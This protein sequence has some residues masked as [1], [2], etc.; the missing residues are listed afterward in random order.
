MST[1]QKKFGN[2]KIR[3]WLRYA[4]RWEGFYEFRFSIPTFAMHLYV[5]ISPKWLAR[6]WWNVHTSNKKPHRFQIWCQNRSLRPQLRQPSMVSLDHDQERI[7][8]HAAC[9]I[10]VTWSYRKRWHVG[11][12]CDCSIF[13]TTGVNL[14]VPPCVQQASTREYAFLRCDLI[15]STAQ[16]DISLF[17]CKGPECGRF[18]WRKWQKYCKIMIRKHGWLLKE[19]LVATNKYKPPDKSALGLP[20]INE[21]DEN[22][23][24]ESHAL[25]FPSIS[26]RHLCEIRYLFCMQWSANCKDVDTYIKVNR[27][28]NKTLVWSQPTNLHYYTYLKEILDSIIIRLPPSDVAW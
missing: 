4:M 19:T 23:T 20:A 10:N 27:I 22:T 5:V 1:L 12:R 13:K 15:L 17:K 11:W 6:I 16:T 28:K 25:L 7:Q 26:A 2:C 24:K 3:V 8:L 9:V 14:H 21:L 18:Q